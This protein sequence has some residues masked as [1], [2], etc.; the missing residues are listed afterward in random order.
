MSPPQWYFWKT[1]PL[2]GAQN[3]AW[4]ELR[5]RLAKDE[6]YPLLRFYSWAEPA[7]TFGRFQKFAEVRDWTAIRP[8]FRRPTGGGLVP[9]I[10]DWTYSLVFPSGDPWHRIRAQASYLRLHQWIQ[11]ALGNLGFA[12]EL[13]PAQKEIP[14]KAGRC[15]AG[16]EANDLVFSGRKIAGAAQKRARSGLLIQSSIQPPPPAIARAEWENAILEAATEMWNVQWRP[17]PEPSAD[18]VC[19]AEELAAEKY[20]RPKYNQLR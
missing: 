14:G 8:L 20:A 4:D 18:L 6:G 19:Q 9:H 2:P 16:A 17:L 1:A 3:M 12:T 13:A 5:L 15:F 10:N 11:T 7:A